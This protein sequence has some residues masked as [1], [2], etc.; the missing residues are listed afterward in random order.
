MK[1]TGRQYYG[2]GKY[3][4]GITTPA[5]FI[6]AGFGKQF[7]VTGFENGVLFFETVKVRLKNKEVNFLKS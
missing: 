2:G 3:R 5:G 4:T 1:K 6:A 7:L